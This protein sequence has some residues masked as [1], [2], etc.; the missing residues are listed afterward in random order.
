MPP[1]GDWSHWLILAGRGFGK[2]RTGAEWIRARVAS[3]QARHIALLAPTLGDARSVMVEGESGLLAIS[4]AHERPH[5]EPSK[6]LLTWPCGARARL[7]SADQPERLR[8]PQ[9]D[10]LWADELCAWRYADQAWDMAM[11]GLRLGVQPR[12][13]ITTTPKPI[14]LL[15]R[16]LD[17]EATAVTRGSTYDNVHNLAPSFAR[18]IIGKYEN[19]RLG[20]QELDAE[21]LWDV[22]GALWSRASLEAC[23]RPAPVGL[24]RIVVAVD[25]PATGGAGADACGIV[26]AGISAGWGGADDRASGCARSQAFVLGDRSCQGLTPHGWAARVV[27]AYHDMRADMVIAEGN[28]GGDMVGALIQQIDPAIPVRRVHARRGKYLRAEP[29]AALYEQGRVFHD[30]PMPDL[31]D[32]MATFTGHEGGRGQS[33]DRLDALVWALSDLM[34]TPRGQP[35]L[36][37]L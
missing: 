31:E 1:P 14:P 2:T 32:Q 21:V 23:R 16:L 24:A 26:I 6:Q 10:T 28:Q 34:L 11:F 17:A 7:F 8:G 5:F 30:H 25:P 27:A 15:R 18:D 13:C 19:T 4:P 33:P 35:R 9:H 22:P 29:V 12:S 3:G 36:R 37:S 20:R